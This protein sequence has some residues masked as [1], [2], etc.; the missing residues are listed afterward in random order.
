[1]RWPLIAASVLVP[2]ASRAADPPKDKQTDVPFSNPG[3]KYRVVGKLGVPFGEVVKVQGVVVEGPFKGYEGGSNLRVQRVNGKATQ[4]DVQIKLTGDFEK[5]GKSKLELPKAESGKT[6]EFEGYETGQFVGIPWEAYKRQELILQTTGHYFHHE[7]IVYTGK[8]T[9]AIAWSP[10]DFVDREALL[11]GKAVSRDKKAYIDGDGWKL[12]TD[13]AAAWPKEL[14]GK[15]VEGLGTMRKADGG[16]KLEKGVTRLV[17]LEDQKGRAVEL[18]GTAWSRNDHWWFDYRGTPLYVEDMAKLPGWKGDLHGGPV[19]IT[20]S[21]DEADMLD[22]DR[23]SLDTNPPKKKYYIVR[24]AG[25][26]S[27]DALLSHE[28]VERK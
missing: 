2:F 6:Y 12:L 22:I 10:A 3:N 20:G 18:R 24:K 7:L 14:E 21:L 27:L 5:K 13:A 1:M 26:K 23:I 8:A 9:D 19:L 11:E 17:K 15:T 4:E 28:R 25:W 16:Y